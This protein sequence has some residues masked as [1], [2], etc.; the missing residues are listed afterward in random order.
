M[1]KNINWG[2]IGLGKI[3]NKFAKDLV[4]VKD[5]ELIAVASRDLTKAEKFAQDHNVDTSYGSYDDILMDENVDVIYVATPHAFHHQITM[6]SIK[7]NKAVL[8]EKPFAMNSREVEEI[9]NYSRKREIFVMEALWTIFLP[10]Y[11]FVLD[12]INSGQY[13]RVLSLKADFG[14]TAEFDKSKRLFNKSLGGGSL[15]DIGIYPVFAAHSILGIPEKIQANANFAET[16]VDLSCNINF[17]YSNGAKAEL[18]STFEEKTETTATIELEKAKIHIHSRFHE[19]TSVTI[20]Q[21]AK[22]ERFDFKVDTIGYNFEA[23]HVTQ[24]LLTNKKESDVMNLTRSLELTR[25]LDEIRQEIGL[26]Y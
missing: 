25:L 9:I 4:S 23:E 5:A 18:L 6:E 22:E 10:H 15:L 24:M 17:E 1:K 2:I 7:H 20:I 12:R 14:F 13:G 3:A 11:Q 8:C 26:K 21:N 19:P 16:G